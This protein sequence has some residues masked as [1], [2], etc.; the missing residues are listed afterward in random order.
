MRK[1]KAVISIGSY[2]K[3]KKGKVSSFSVNNIIFAVNF[4]VIQ[5]IVFHLDYQI[6]YLFIL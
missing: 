5:S 2:Q 6:H 4:H 3:I 1:V